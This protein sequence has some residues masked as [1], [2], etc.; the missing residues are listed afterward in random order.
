[1]NRHEFVGF[2]VGHASVGFVL[3]MC[4]LSA[5]DRMSLKERA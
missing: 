4:W 2:M 3:N 1:L 5:P